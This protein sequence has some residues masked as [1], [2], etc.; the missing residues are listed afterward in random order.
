MTRTRGA[1]LAVVVVAQVGLFAAAQA[2]LRRRPAGQV[3]GSKRLWRLA[4][5]LN[6]VGPVAYFARGRR[7]VAPG[8]DQTAAGG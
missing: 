2:D 6:F 8:V 3:N 4:T 1:V 7:D 5:F